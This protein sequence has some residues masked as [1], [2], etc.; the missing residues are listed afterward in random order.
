MRAGTWISRSLRRARCE[1]SGFTLIELIASLIVV[2]LGVIALITTLDSSR[3]LISF[4][5]RKE[6]AVHAG[7]QELERIQ[8]LAYNDIATD[9]PPA[10]CGSDP[11]DVNNPVYYVEGETW[12]R[13]DQQ[14]RGQK[15]D[16]AGNPKLNCELL[17]TDSTT[18]DGDPVGQVPAARVEITENGPTGGTRLKVELQR[19]VTWV[20]D[21]CVKEPPNVVGCTGSQ[22]Y[23]R[24]TVAVR[25]VGVVDGVREKL[26][27]GGP[28]RPILLSTTVRPPS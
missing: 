4:A 24:I 1:E 8:A 22:D 11:C 17:V 27:N 14:P 19:F 12:Y 16:A 3:D 25:V 20:D 2:S 7:E 13:W 18:G 26:L 5:E 9:G 15:C 6:S 21:D 28:G 23:K 10:A